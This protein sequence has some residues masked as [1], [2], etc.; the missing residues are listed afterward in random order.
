VLYAL[1]YY[2]QSGQVKLFNQC[3]YIDITYNCWLYQRWFPN[4][5]VINA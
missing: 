3:N 1:T 4:K 2:E 5:K